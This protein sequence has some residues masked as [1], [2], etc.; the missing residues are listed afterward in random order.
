[1]YQGQDF[2]MDAQIKQFR[3]TL[4]ELKLQLKGGLEDFIS[5]SLIVSNMGTNDYLNNYLVDSDKRAKYT[6]DAFNDI[7][8]QNYTKQME[9]IYKKQQKKC[10]FIPR[11]I[12]NILNLNFFYRIYTTWVFEIS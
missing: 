9:V 7:L 4:N 1:M 8:I 2:S 11:I 5:N 10:E 12:V 3:G 6:P